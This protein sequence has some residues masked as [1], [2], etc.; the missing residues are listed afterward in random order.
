VRTEQHKRDRENDEQRKNNGKSDSD[1]NGVNLDIDKLP[2]D[3]ERRLF[4][5][6]WLWL[7][8]VGAI[9]SVITAGSWVLISRAITPTAESE[10]RRTTQ[11][12]IGEFRTDIDSL[13]Q[14]IELLQGE[15]RNA[16]T[17]LNR[18]YGRSIE[19]GEQTIADAVPFG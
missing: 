2:P 5:H 12:V 15:G 1:G 13:M 9:A 17:E 4:L 3:L 14:E 19:I 11:K 16:V 10:A 8:I 6:F 7:S 18:I